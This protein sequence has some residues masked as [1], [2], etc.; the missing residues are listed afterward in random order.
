MITG[1]AG[2]LGSH[3][4]LHCL[5]R[6]DSVHLVVRPGSPLDRLKGFEDRLAL[7]RFDTGDKERLGDCFAE[8]KPEQVFHFAS[9]TRWNEEA[10]FGDAFGSVNQDLI[11]LLTLLA[12]ANVARPAP[13][14]VIRAGSLAEYGPGATPF[15]E[16]QREMPISAY[17]AA[18]VAGT[19]YAQMLQPRLSFPVITGRLALVYGLHQSEDFLVPSLIRRCF[20]GQPSTLRRPDDRRDLLYIEDAIDALIRLGSAPPPG[21]GI[22]NIAT[23]MAPTMREVAE[24]VV[25][26]TGADKALLK[27]SEQEDANGVADLRG[28]TALL[29]NLTG[30]EARVP[31]SDGLKSTVASY[32]DRQTAQ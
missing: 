32:R 20:A 9:R 28:S 6:G 5:N 8:A 2:F 14:V 1:G 3:L 23:G 13:Q 27:L 12:T 18:L 16:S 19:H 30:W 29:R 10:G 17:A 11:N 24:L 7:H 25:R 26:L 31:L 21:A 15:L 22:V 4:A